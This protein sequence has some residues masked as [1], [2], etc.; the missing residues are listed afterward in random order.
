MTKY[1]TRPCVIALLLSVSIFVMSCS[2]GK[3]AD[4]RP[5]KDPNYNGAVDLVKC[6]RIGGWVWDSANP[7][8]DIKVDIYVDDKIIGTVPA[9]DPRGDLKHIGP[10]NYGF[11]LAMP[12]E[13][14]DGKPHAVRAKISGG[15][16]EIKVWS[17]IQPTFT[18]NPQ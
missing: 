11:V 12:S 1:V 5:P 18:C 16:Y 3:N 15:T 8:E 17:E 14:K 6:D 13:L 7:N 9:K 4:T 10:S 2:D